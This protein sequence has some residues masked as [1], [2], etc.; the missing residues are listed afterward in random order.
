MVGQRFAL[1]AAAVMA[2]T[3]S[4]WA[5]PAQ[6][7]LW[8]GLPGRDDGFLIDSQTG[9]LWMTGS[10][11]KPLARAEQRGSS[12]VSRTAGMVSVGRA[13][14][15]LDQTFTLDLTPGASSIRIDNPERGGSHVLPS[16]TIPD[17]RA[18][19]ACRARAAA[20]VCED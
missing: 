8:I 15:H 10:C 9:E 17:C 3:L 19:A 20:P 4:A 16:V 12:W 7:D 1:A 13:M 14:V 18:E 2:H 11:L 6:A 5:G